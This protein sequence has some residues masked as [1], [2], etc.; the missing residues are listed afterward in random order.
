MIETDEFVDYMEKKGEELN[1]DPDKIDD[2]EALDGEVIQ[3][4][5]DEGEV[6]KIKSEDSELIRAD[7]DEDATITFI[8]TKDVIMSIA[9]GELDPLEVLNTRKLM[10]KTD[11]A[12][13]RIMRRLFYG[14]DF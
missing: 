5:T 7:D 9:K 11:S 13:G 3:L 10:A 12:K 4:T 8:S 14:E 2:I 6:Y 1:N